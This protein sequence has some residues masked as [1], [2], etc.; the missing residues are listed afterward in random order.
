MLRVVARSQQTTF[1]GSRG[2]ED[3]DRS[4]AA[5]GSAL[6]ARASSINAAVPEALSFAPW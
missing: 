5:T 2:D 4:G 6:E 3:I 1:L